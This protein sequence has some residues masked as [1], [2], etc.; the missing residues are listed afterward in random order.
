MANDSPAP[1]DLRFS[2]SVDDIWAHVSASAFPAGS[3]DESSSSRRVTGSVVLIDGASGTGKTALAAHLASRWPQHREVVVVHMDDLYGGWTGLAA[4]ILGLEVGLFEARA[5]GA[6]AHLRSY[7]WGAGRWEDGP[8]IPAHV[9]VIVEGCGSFGAGG[10]P[11]ATARIWLDAPL[12]VRRERALSRA[13]EDFE[14][15]WD[16]WEGQFVEYVRRTQPVTIA[17]LRVTANR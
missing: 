12:D 7:N 9:D 8:T 4:G 3:A 17:S 16:L 6:D 13:G 1:S 10:S 15:H 11:S 2:P 14:R 5:R